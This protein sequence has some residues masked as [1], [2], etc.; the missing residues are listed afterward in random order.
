VVI[1]IGISLWLQRIR[2]TRVTDGLKSIRWAAENSFGFEALNGAITRT[3]HSLAET[4][5]NTQTGHLSGNV[6]GKVEDVAV[7]FIYIVLG[8]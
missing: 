2:L 8:A 6:L 1:A 3:T 7:L 4:F 5:R